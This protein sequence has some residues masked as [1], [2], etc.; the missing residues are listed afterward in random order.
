MFLAISIVASAG[1]TGIASHYS[2]KTN[3]KQTASGIPLNDSFFTAAHKCLS[4]GTIVKVTNLIN[5]KV[6]FVKITDRGPYIKN[7]IIDLSTS[8]AKFLGFYK[9]GI[10]KVKI[11]VIKKGNNERIKKHIKHPK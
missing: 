5:D 10:T 4:F 9:E 11:E 1:E 7:R 2:T 6:A 3:G 8:T